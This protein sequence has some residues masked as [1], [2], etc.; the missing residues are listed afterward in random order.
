M[1]NTNEFEETLNTE[2]NDTPENETEQEEE[3]TDE[4]L[5][6]AQELARNQKIRA[7]KA[8]AE[9]KKL[10]SAEKETPKNDSFSIK[11][12]KA[13]SSVHDEDIERVEKFAKSEGV[14]IHEALKNEDLKAII[15]NREEQR[16]TAE[17]ANTGGSKRGTYKMSD[18][19][20]LENF[21]KGIIPEKDEDI[22]RLAEAQMAQRKAI[23]KGN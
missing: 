14:P 6:K 22:Q 23:A 5:K 16:K 21:N 1:E 20:L 11:D 17:T 3:Q 18:E 10:K 15:R 4:E 12:I 2:E 7:E 19:T 8:E 9:I 13:L